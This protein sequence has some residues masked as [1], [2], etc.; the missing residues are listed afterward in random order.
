MVKPRIASYQHKDS[1]AIVR[2]GDGSW[3]IISPNKDNEGAY[4]F[5]SARL[6]RGKGELVA[7]AANYGGD[8]NKFWSPDEITQQQL[9]DYWD[10][11]VEEAERFHEFCI[12]EDSWKIV[13][14]GKSVREQ[15][16]RGELQSLGV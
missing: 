3:L 9:A 13:T 15:L 14:A 5:R 16:S 2:Y 11:A 7:M 6:Y 4:R 10:S 1:S 8:D 12:K